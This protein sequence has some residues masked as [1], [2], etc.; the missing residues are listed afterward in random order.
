MRV[1]GNRKKQNKTKKKHGNES[2]NQSMMTTFNLYFG[3]TLG[4]QLQRQNDSLGRAMHNSSTSAAQGNTLAHDVA[5][6]Y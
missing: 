5:K 6:P 2:Q 1:V 4:E 3:C